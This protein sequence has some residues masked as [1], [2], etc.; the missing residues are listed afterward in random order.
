M[1]MK[2]D[3]TSICGMSLLLAF[4]IGFFP[5]SAR[6][7][8]VNSD[9]KL[10]LQAEEEH[11]FGFKSGLHHHRPQVMRRQSRSKPS[12]L[13]A[14]KAS[15][16]SK[17]NVWQ[18]CKT[19]TI[20][21]C[22]SVSALRVND[23]KGNCRCTKA[24]WAS[25]RQ[26]LKTLCSLSWGSC[27]TNTFMSCCEKDVPAVRIDSGNDAGFG[28]SRQ[29][30]CADAQYMQMAQPAIE[31]RCRES[32][33]MLQA[34][35]RDD[36][37]LRDDEAAMTVSPA[38]SQDATASSATASEDATTATPSEDA[39]TATATA[40]EDATTATPSEDAST[41]TAT[42][43]EDAT[44]ATPSEDAT[45][46]TATASED[47]TAATA[48]EDP[49]K[50]KKKK[51]KKKKDPATATATASEDATTN[52][53]ASSEVQQCSSQKFGIDLCSSWCNSPGKWGCGVSKL[54]GSDS[55]NTDNIDYSC[56]CAGCNGCPE[57]AIYLDYMVLSNREQ[58]FTAGTCTSNCDS[59]GGALP[60]QY[61]SSSDIEVL[62]VDPDDSKTSS[63]VLASSSLNFDTGGTYNIYVQLTFQAVTTG[64]SVAP[65][66]RL[67]LNSASWLGP[68]GCSGFIK[69]G[70]NH[71]VSSSLV[72]T[73][74]TVKSG[75]TVSVYIAAQ[76]DTDH[77]T[78]PASKS[79]ISA[80]HLASRR[81]IAQ[82]TN[83]Q[84]VQDHAAAQFADWTAIDVWEA[85]PSS[86]PGGGSTYISE[87]FYLAEGSSLEVKKAGTYL[88]V[89]I[90]NVKAAKATVNV[91]L[92]ASIKK[93]GNKE[94]WA[95]CIGASIYASAGSTTGP[96]A[97]SYVRTVANLDAGSKVILYSK[98]LS[99]E[100]TGTIIAHPG[101][102]EFSLT[103][104]DGVQGYV[105]LVNKEQTFSS[106]NKTEG[107]IAAK[108]GCSESLADW[109][110]IAWES[111]V[112][113]TNEGQLEVQTSGDV[114]TMQSSGVTCTKSG[115]VEVIVNMMFSAAAGD[116]QNTI[117]RIAKND[118]F[119]GP[120]G[121]MSY[122][123]T[124]N[125]HQLTSSHVSAIF[126]VEPGTEIKVFAS[127]GKGEQ[128][129]PAGTGEFIVMQIPTESD[130]VKAEEAAKA[131][132]AK[133]D[134]EE[135]KTEE[136]SRQTT[137]QCHSTQLVSQS[138]EDDVKQVQGAAEVVETDDGSPVVTFLSDD[139]CKTGEPGSLIV[140]L[141]AAEGQQGMLR[142]QASHLHD[143][144]KADIAPAINVTAEGKSE[145]RT[146]SMSSAARTDWQWI[147]VP[148]T[149]SSNETLVR[150]EPTVGA[151]ITVGK[152]EYV[153]C[154]KEPL[155]PDRT[156]SEAMDVQ[157]EAAKLEVDALHAKL[158]KTRHLLQQEE[159]KEVKAE[160]EVQNEAGGV[161][162]AAAAGVAVFMLAVGAIIG[163]KLQKKQPEQPLHDTGEEELEEEWE[164]WEEGEDEGEG[165]QL[166]NMTPS[167]VM[168][169]IKVQA[170]FRGW[171]ARLVRFGARKKDE[172]R[173]LEPDMAIVLCFKDIKL[174]GVPDVNL[175]GGVDPFL[176]F[177]SGFTKEPQNGK[178]TS[179]SG[180]MSRKTEIEV[181]NSASF[182]TDIAL[183]MV[184][185]KPDQW[186]NILLRDSGTAG[187]TFVGNVGVPVSKFCEALPKGV[188]NF[189]KK[190]IMEQSFEINSVIGGSP[191]VSF[192]AEV[193]EALKFTF[194]IGEGSTFPHVDQFGSIDSFIELRACRTATKD[195]FEHKADRDPKCIWSAK[196]A[197]IT[198]SKDPVFNQELNG[199]LPGDPDLQ[200]QVIIWDNSLTGNTPIAHCFVELNS[201]VCEKIDGTLPPNSYKI[202]FQRIPGHNPFEGYNNAELEFT[203]QARRA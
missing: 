98:R 185:N 71:A 93:K 29:C 133:L 143:K 6:N 51:K 58:E 127:N 142:F 47:A 72:S 134:D 199:T 62:W 65:C 170:A 154:S 183:T 9:A 187:D 140:S 149:A 34:S 56:T 14:S 45:T 17:T 196:T 69:D 67:R 202:K 102:S 76:G 86:K 132:K 23:G 165:V 138:V 61:W 30:A 195:A 131:A 200:L 90:W 88:I 21:Q 112:G 155:E 26:K 156:A 144:N 141:A 147:Q 46:A 107:C 176:E 178:E 192:K 110:E 129:A 55:K 181:G 81:G 174:S 159:T 194:R 103:K 84:Q 28:Y 101:F 161:P 162:L 15:K 39:S 184:V 116:Q 125:G 167:D 157:L 13:T 92:R 169:L 94:R 164:E 95:G 7:I 50:K 182:K 123:S 41:A 139:L 77:F 60:E 97:T 4:A 11:G 119:I 31:N 148:F 5:G 79:E 74:A 89:A 96:W 120:E 104:L 201:A 166:T 171:K 19:V 158:N 2:V 22:C 105:V 135:V 33:Q 48:S 126:E 179:A 35:L 12:A 78:L 1:H 106:S 177:Q 118:A 80:K 20:S 38:A 27:K 68:V 91:G 8:N 193:F 136:V 151:C 115:T 73:L 3:M 99:D 100:T 128:K 83:K 109:N 42:A 53:I 153:V 137:M 57:E 24:V 82:M 180:D 175:L 63:V 59:S 10:V 152:L 160:T 32:R 163:N 87:E 191:S 190:A 117:V 197:V 49:A 168:A 145:L 40:S 108:K 172:E 122:M 114:F 186:I 18:P 70:V 150:M 64:K 198:D 36:G 146:V 37:K 203:V 25:A 16:S 54:E 75:D 52:T 111:E 113:K 173:K 43:S 188:F 121:S 130:V 85:S 124:E 44:A 189:Q 66:I